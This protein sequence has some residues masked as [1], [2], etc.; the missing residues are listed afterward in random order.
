[1]VILLASNGA[2][3]DLLLMESI[4]NLVST[5]ALFSSSR[6]KASRLALTSP[7]VLH[8]RVKSHKM[9]FHNV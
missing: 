1:M 9:Q 3:K 5:S 2:V 8:K 4:A 6:F 7:I